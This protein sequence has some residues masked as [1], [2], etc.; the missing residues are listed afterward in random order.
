MPKEAI[1]KKVKNHLP[2]STIGEDS[3]AAPALVLSIKAFSEASG[4]LPVS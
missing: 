2:K 1:H 4:V 3:V